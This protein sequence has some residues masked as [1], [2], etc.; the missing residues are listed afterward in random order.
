MSFFTY[1]VD[2]SDVI[3][4]VQI[5]ESMERIPRP[6]LGKLSTYFYSAVGN[7]GTVKEDF[8]DSFLV[9]HQRLL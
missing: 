8:V 7:V 3:E 5:D 9:T 4:Y 2:V 6:V 1:I